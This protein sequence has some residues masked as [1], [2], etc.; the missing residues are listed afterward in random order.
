MPLKEKHAVERAMPRLKKKEWVSI[1][2]STKFQMTSTRLEGEV[3]H[4]RG[5]KAH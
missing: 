3:G 5:V 4:E 2:S 1:V